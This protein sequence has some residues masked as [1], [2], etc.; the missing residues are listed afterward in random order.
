MKRELPPS[1]PGFMPK[2]I[3]LSGAPSSYGFRALKRE[4]E[5]LALEL[6]WAAAEKA[7]LER[8]KEEHAA[9]QTEQQADQAA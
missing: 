3:G 6:I 5:K 4:T 1:G 9:K 8:R 2:R 7:K